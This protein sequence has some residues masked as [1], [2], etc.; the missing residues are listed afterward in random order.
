[1]ERKRLWAAALVSAAAVIMVLVHGLPA[2]EQEAQEEMVAILTPASD[3]WPAD[4]GASLGEGIWDAPVPLAGAPGEREDPYLDQ[5]VA[6]VNEE[7]GKAGVAPLEISGPVCAAASIR[8]DEIV[9]SFSHTRPDGSPY[10]TVLSQAGIGYR[11]CGENVAYGYRTPEE[12]MAGWMAA[13]LG[14]SSLMLLMAFSFGNVREFLRAEA[15]LLFAAAL[16][17]GILEWG[18]TAWLALKGEPMQMSALGLLP[19]LFFLAGGCF[20]RYRR[21]ALHIHGA[22]PQLFPV[23]APVKQF[24]PILWSR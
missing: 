17:E 14:V 21:A 13:V 6:L 2:G 16:T 9:T 10:K 1:M 12:V 8:A 23:S 3:E 24:V 19:G 5:L 22:P 4:D 20:L 18:R 7:R 11:N 15:G